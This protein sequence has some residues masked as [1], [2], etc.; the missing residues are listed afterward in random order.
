MYVARLRVATAFLGRGSENSA[1]I[2][3]R[4]PSAAVDTTPFEVMVQSEAGSE[5]YE[6]FLVSCLRVESTSEKE[7]VRG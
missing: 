4:L 5:G 6:G 2:Q 7:E 1:Y 3:N